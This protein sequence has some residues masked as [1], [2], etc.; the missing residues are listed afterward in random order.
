MIIRIIGWS[1]ISL[2]FNVCYLTF[3]LTVNVL[4]MTIM[5][6]YNILMVHVFIFY[7]CR[8]VGITMSLPKIFVGNKLTLI[9]QILKITNLYVSIIQVIHLHFLDSNI[10]YTCVLYG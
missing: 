7:F 10:S 2:C 6:C 1:L 3:A 5:C 8:L 4:S 9:A